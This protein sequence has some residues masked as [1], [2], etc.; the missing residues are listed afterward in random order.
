MIRNS[1][2]EFVWAK[3]S[4]AK[5]RID[6]WT[7]TTTC[8]LLLWVSGSWIT[9]P[10]VRNSCTA[11]LGSTCRL[12]SL[13]CFRPH[14]TATR[15][16]TDDLHQPWLLEREKKNNVWIFIKNFQDQGILSKAS[17]YN[18]YAIMNPWWKRI[19]E[20]LLLCCFRLSYSLWK[21]WAM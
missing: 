11:F 16:E 14:Y 5:F 20:P 10:F 8:L 4:L 2:Y 19:T 15:V 1:N 21:W 7:P 17:G 3:Y 9:V 18:F 6:L 12:I 13:K